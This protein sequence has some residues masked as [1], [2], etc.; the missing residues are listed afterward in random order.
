[1][2]ITVSD[3]SVEVVDVS[4]QLLKKVVSCY[5]PSKALQ[6]C[7]R[8]EVGLSAE[9]A[10]DLGFTDGKFQSNVRVF[11][12]VPQ[13]GSNCFLYPKDYGAVSWPPTLDHPKDLWRCR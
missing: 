7:L 9:I 10:I 1:M 2:S 3:L 4:L 12:R 6:F 13:L 8:L 5:D 11:Q